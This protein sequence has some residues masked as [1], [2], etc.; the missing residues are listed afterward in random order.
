M[1]LFPVLYCTPDTTENGDSILRR[2]PL[3][4][5]ESRTACRPAGGQSVHSGKQLANVLAA[6][7]AASAA[8]RNVFSGHQLAP[9]LA[10]W[11]R[12][13]LETPWRLLRLKFGWC[14]P[15]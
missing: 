10:L 12:H 9:R 8:R 11:G 5:P 15:R 4:L 7:G 3:D 2:L 14:F 13:D 6:D 1:L